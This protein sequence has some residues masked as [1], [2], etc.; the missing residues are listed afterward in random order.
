MRRGIYTTLLLVI[1]SSTELFSKT[2][3]SIK[4][5]GY[6][7]VLLKETYDEYDSKGETV[8]F[9]KKEKS[10]DLTFV[11]SFVLE[12]ATGGCNDKSLEHGVY[13]VNGT[14]LTL[15][16]LWER[17][18]SVDDA[19]FGGRIQRYELSKSGEMQLH[20]SQLYVE[21]HTKGADP[22]SGMKFLFNAPKTEEEKRSLAKYVK[23]VEKYFHG[24][25]IF[26]DKAKALMIE[27]RK[28]Q[29]E[30]ITRRWGR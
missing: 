21:K 23:S 8:A 4:I 19:P 28:A 15:Y 2:W 3:D 22:K 24:D 7:F 26:G 20:S 11:L 16:T 27:I 14:M 30:Q 1:L 17:Q 6:P 18:G 5:D 25:F 12:D 10:K 9:Y 29:K 13:E